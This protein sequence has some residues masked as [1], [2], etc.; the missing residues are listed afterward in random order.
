MC[1]CR[2]FADA[3]ELRK[4]VCQQLDDY[5]ETCKWI[6]MNLVLFKEDIYHVCMIVRIIG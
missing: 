2:E 5:N 3:E 4:Y 1:P 6:P